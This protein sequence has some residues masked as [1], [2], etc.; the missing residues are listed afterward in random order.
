MKN[1]L[2][3]RY[4]VYIILM[5]GLIYLNEYIIKQTMMYTRENFR[6]NYFLVIMTMLIKICIGLLLGIEY[7]FKELRKNGVWKINYPKVVFMI[8]PSLYFSLTYLFM[9]NVEN[10]L[11]RL[12]TY[13]LSSFLKNGTNFVSI[14]QI[15]IGYF[16][17]T[18][19]YK[20]D[21][22][23]TKKEIICIFR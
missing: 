3:L 12:F 6:F 18:S 15:I 20:K 17:I 11:Q 9:D 7:L 8:I 13:P 21:N 10:P 1:N 4:G 23:N 16:L 14:F 19:F 5:V 2:W 22:C